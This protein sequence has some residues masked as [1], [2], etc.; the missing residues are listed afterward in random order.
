MPFDMGHTWY[1]CLH[2]TATDGDFIKPTAQEQ[3]RMNSLINTRTN[4]C[5]LLN[6]LISRCGWEGHQI[7]LLG[8]S[9]GAQ[10]ALDLAANYRPRLGQ[11]IKQDNITKVTTATGTTDQTTGRQRL[12]GVVLLS[13]SLMEEVYLKHLDSQSTAGTAQLF[14]TPL[15]ISHGS[16]DQRIPLS[17]ARKYHQYI[18]NN[19]IV[20]GPQS[21]SRESPKTSD[22]KNKNKTK[23][24]QQ[25]K[26]DS[27]VIFKV[28]PK[29]HQMVCQQQEVKDLMTFFSERLVLRAIGLENTPGVYQVN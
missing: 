28:Y 2:M 14:H 10:V 3:R 11:D 23:N 20:G 9:M 13:S 8:F 16:K 1:K 4:L 22:R 17:L 6:T 5:E 29:G 21:A 15:F 24:K 12:G 27:E 7:F 25:P 18:V 19:M 26:S